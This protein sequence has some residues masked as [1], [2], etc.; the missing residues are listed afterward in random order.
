MKNF[1]DYYSLC[2]DYFHNW[3]TEKSGQACRGRMSYSFEDLYS[4]ST[5]IGKIVKTKKS[6]QDIFLL[7]Y[8]N[9][10][11]T[12]VG[13]RNIALSCA[14]I[15]VVFLTYTEDLKYDSI[16]KIV[17]NECK[18]LF[19]TIKKMDS[20]KKKDTNV[21]AELKDLADRQQSSIRFLVEEFRIKG[22]L[23]S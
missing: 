5:V 15:K 17:K 6:K 20:K 1:R 8:H 7:D 16:E 23:K 9:Y 4:Y 13:H 19:D 11:P 14:N 2:H 18:Y 22:K 10:S 21:Y 12:T 3:Q